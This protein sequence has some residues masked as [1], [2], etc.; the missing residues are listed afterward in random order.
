MPHHCNAV[1]DQFQLHVQQRHAPKD[2]ER[3][4]QAHGPHPRLPVDD[5][6]AHLPEGA[7][8]VDDGEELHAVEEEG[9]LGDEDNQD[10]DDKVTMVVLGDAVEQEET[11]VVQSQHALLTQLAV[12]GTYRDDNLQVGWKR[13]TDNGKTGSFFLETAR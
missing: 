7:A 10:E 3:V 13:K 11:V 6:H 12:F 1:G 5:G 8:R 9:D 4:K 2:G